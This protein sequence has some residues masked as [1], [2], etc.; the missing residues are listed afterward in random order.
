MSPL[1]RTTNE[2]REWLKGLSLEVHSP[3][4]AHQYK[5]ILSKA[6]RLLSMIEFN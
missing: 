1:E 6:R 5:K 2:T 3:I 4:S